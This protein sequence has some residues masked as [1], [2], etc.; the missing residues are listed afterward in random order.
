VYLA[1]KP[2]NRS[3]A[4]DDG[5]FS[6]WLLSQPRLQVHDATLLWRDEKA[7][8]P[9]VRLSNVQIEVR[10]KGKHHLASLTALPPAHLAGPI[11]LRADVVMERVGETWAATGTGYGSTGRT[12]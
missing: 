10:R 3:G 8:Q 6:A 4:G 1:D 7:N 2:L 9:Q 12:D 5:A 11:A